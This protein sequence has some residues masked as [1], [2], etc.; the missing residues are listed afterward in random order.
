M[1]RDMNEEVI[2]ALAAGGVG[3]LP[4]DTIY[5]V[6]GSALSPEAVD[7]IYALKRRDRRKPLIVLIADIED[8]ERFGVVLSDR[9]RATL[10]SYWPH[11][12]GALR[13][14]R[15]GKPTSVILPLA[16]D[17]F[18]HLDRGTDTLAFRLPDD[19]ELRTLLREVGPL[20]APSANVEGGAPARTIEE[21][22]RY[23]GGD[24]DFYVD[25]GVREGEPS[26]VIA[27]DDDGGVEVVRE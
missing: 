15:R 18:T 26:A 4:T 23:F 20:V 27:L 2:A 12:A 13:D 10:E 8:V 11:S 22:R 24:V 21:A 7:R 6:V 25:G 9:L 19:E 17:S 14:E 3:I 16:D 5:G 1:N